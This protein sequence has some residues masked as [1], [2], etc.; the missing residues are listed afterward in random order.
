MKKLRQWIPSEC[1]SKSDRIFRKN[2][3]EDRLAV[4]AAVS[5]PV[6]YAVYQSA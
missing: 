1:F 2:R 5:E 4:K 6:F 3:F